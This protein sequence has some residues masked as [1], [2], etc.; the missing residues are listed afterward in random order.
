M[1]IYLK[2]LGINL[3]RTLSWNNHINTMAK[4][5]SNIISAFLQRN[6]HQHPR[7]SKAQ[8]YQKLVRP[9][10]EYDCTIWDPHTKEN[11][12]KLEAEQRRSARFVYNDFR[13]TTSVT[14]MLNELNWGPLQEQRAQYKVIMMYCIVHGLVDIPTTHLT[15][16]ATSVRGHMYRYKIPFARTLKYQRSFFPDTIRIW[17]K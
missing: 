3:N 15:P 13:H 2:R 17:N 12:N 7:K 9:L 11:I 5:A 1:D 16:Q 4:K 6:L 14:P 8:C 10:M